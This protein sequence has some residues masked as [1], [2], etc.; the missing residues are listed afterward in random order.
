MAGA[1][2]VL[3]L[4]AIFIHYAVAEGLPAIASGELPLLRPAVAAGL[5]EAVA[6][7]SFA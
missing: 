4:A 5:P 1:L 6:V 3:A 7:L 2:F